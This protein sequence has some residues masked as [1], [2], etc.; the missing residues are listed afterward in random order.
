MLPSEVIEVE[1][2]FQRTRVC[3]KKALEV[4]TKAHF[5]CD[6]MPSPIRCALCDRIVDDAMKYL[7][8]VRSKR[9]LSNVRTDRM[10][11]HRRE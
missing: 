6:G 7:G 2:L 1:R 9:H 8:H 4:A 11:L 10:F 5:Q 3:S